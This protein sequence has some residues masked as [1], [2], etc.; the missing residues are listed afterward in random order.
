MWWL[1]KDALPLHVKAKEIV[2]KKFDK[3][4]R[5]FCEEENIKLKIWP[6]ISILNYLLYDNVEE[7]SFAAGVYVWSSDKKTGKQ[8]YDD[9]YPCIHLPQ[10][11]ITY[12]LAHEI[13]HHLAIKNFNDRSETTANAFI[14][15]LAEEYLT[16][17]ERYIISIGLEV[18]SHIKFPEI[19]VK[20]RDWKKFK[21]DHL[22]NKKSLN[23]I[24][25]CENILKEFF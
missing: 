14:L 15:L 22:K 11:Y 19:D 16:D 8:K 21:K 18:F 12:T 3:C 24:Q 23:I 9:K 7:S 13:G 4:L 5:K 6:S 1:T 2:L 25:R 10:D 17:I 20:R